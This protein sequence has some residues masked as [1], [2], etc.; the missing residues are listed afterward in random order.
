MKRGKLLV[1]EYANN[2]VIPESLRLFSLDQSEALPM[3]KI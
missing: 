1:S 2:E 3:V